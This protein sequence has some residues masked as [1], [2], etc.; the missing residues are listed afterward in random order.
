MDLVRQAAKPGPEVPLGNW[1]PIPSS[2]TFDLAMCLYAPRDNAANGSWRPLALTPTSRT[3]E[4][5]GM[6]AG[7]ES[8]SCRPRRSR[9]TEARDPL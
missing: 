5:A 8:R 4:H 7:Q 6:S 3:S 9:A 1:L 2:G